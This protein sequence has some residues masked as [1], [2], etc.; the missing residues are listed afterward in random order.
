MVWQQLQELPDP[1]HY[2]LLQRRKNIALATITIE[3]GQCETASN[4][5]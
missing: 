1:I 5:W 2:Y 3:I 4:L